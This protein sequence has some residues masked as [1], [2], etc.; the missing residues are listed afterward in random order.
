M[1]RKTP[2]ENHIYVMTVFR[3]RVKTPEKYSTRVWGWYPT[4]DEANQAVRKNFGDMFECGYYQMAL[5]EKMNAGC[6]AMCEQEWW[7][8]ASYKEGKTKVTRTKKPKQFEGI[9]HFSMG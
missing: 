4:F 1:K 3:F 5:I 6:V 7:Y 2:K 8:K 9:V